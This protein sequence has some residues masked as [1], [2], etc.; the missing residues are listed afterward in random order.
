MPFMAPRLFRNLKPLAR[1]SKSFSDEVLSALLLFASR[2]ATA[3]ATYSGATAACSPTSCAARILRRTNTTCRVA[4]RA[5]RTAAASAA[6]FRTNLH[7]RA[8]N[9]RAVGCG[10][11]E[12]GIAASSLAGPSRATGSNCIRNA[13]SGSERKIRHFRICAAASTISGASI[14]G[15]AS[16]T[17]ADNFN[18]IV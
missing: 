4:S 14:A 11:A 1:M 3:S 13:R 7:C 12:V 8:R 10:I 15:P 6:T 2:G 16:T 9:A 18:R 17:T 5:T